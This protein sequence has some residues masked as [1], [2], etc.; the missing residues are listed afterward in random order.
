[1]N[2]SV[3]LS[4][5]LAALCGIVGIGTLTLTG[6]GG[7][8]SS[9]V[10][11]G[12][13]SGNLPSFGGRS[14]ESTV[15]LA[16]GQTGALRLST[17]PNGTATGTFAIDDGVT[18]RLV[19]ATPL[20]SGTFDPV[21]GGFN[22]SGAYA[23][24]GQN[25]PIS[26]SG[27]LPIPPSQ[28]GGAITVVVNGETY[29]SSF[30]TAPLPSPGVTP[31]PGSPIPSPSAS[32]STGALRFQLVS[33]SADCNFS[34]AG[35][36]GLPVESATLSGGA[37]AGLYLFAGTLKSGNTSLNISWQRLNAPNGLVPETFTFVPN[38]EI[39]PFGDDFQGVLGTAAIHQIGQL[40]VGAW[41]PTGG[42]LIVESV[43]GKTVRVRGE[44]VEFSPNRFNAISAKGTFRANFT[45]TFDNVSGL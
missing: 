7:S 39:G 6:C 25:F 18:S 36:T 42:N 20:L 8:S 11:P 32:P 5:A 43:V 9:F 4:A 14:Y 41:S 37:S 35:F 26:L 21:T 3:P 23:F 31:T 27:T 13:G 33:K 10:Q 38:P 2:R 28:T 29:T 15:R 12:G 16:N 40:S 24:N 45:V 19:I 44:N 22:L 30:S 17:N 1:M 34:E